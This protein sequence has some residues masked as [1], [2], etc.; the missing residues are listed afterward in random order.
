MIIHIIIVTYNGMSWLP[1]CLDSCKDYSVVIVDNGSTDGTLDYI[2]NNY[3]TIILLKQGKNLGF[4]HANNIG[5]M[6]ALDKGTEY[7]FLLNQ[8]AYLREGCLKNLVNAQR[9]NPIYGILSPIHLNGLGERLDRKFSDYVS[10]KYNLDFYSD[11]VLEKTLQDVYEVPFVNAAGWLLSR[12]ILEVVGG[13]D[14]IFFHYGEDENY[15]QRAIYHG[16]KI[17]VV[18]TAFMNHDREERPIKEVSHYKLGSEEY[19]RNIETNLKVK[20]GNINK[21]SAADFQA[22]L[23]KRIKSKWKAYVQLKFFRAANLQRE[24]ELI[25]SLKSQIDSSVK[26]NKSIGKNI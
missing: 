17:G 12:R 23:A 7:V 2:E 5:I 20:F 19:I 13:F 6:Y 18:P 15:C 11:F 9:M 8:D 3:P 21:D 26:Q 22:L 4:G 14:P 16:F 25:R 1:K 10:H 24:I